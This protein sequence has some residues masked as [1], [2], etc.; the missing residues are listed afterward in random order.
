MDY[1]QYIIDI[2]CKL[3]K[4]EYIN[5]NKI[6]YLISKCSISHIRYSELWYFLNVDAQRTVQLLNSWLL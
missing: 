1:N 3:I 2:P 6:W 4:E 5:Q